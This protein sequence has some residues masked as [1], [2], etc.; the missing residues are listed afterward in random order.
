[1]LVARFGGDDDGFGFDF[2]AVHGEH[3]RLFGKIHGFDDAEAGARA[4]A[5]GLFLH[6]SHQ[7]VAVHA[8]GAGE[9]FRPM[10]V[11]V[12]RPPGCWPVSTS[13]FKSARAG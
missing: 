1:M 5:L 6:P 3:E 9:I 2:L 13:G 10:S 7:F 8:F 4:E 11:V 12:S